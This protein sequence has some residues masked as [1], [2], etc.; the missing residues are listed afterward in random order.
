MGEFVLAQT[1]SPT[2]RF[3]SITVDLRT[4]DSGSADR[5]EHIR[6]DTFETAKYP[7]AL[8]TAE[9]VPVFSG[10]YSDGQDI[11]F[12]LPGELT[13]HGVTHAVTFAVEGKLSANTV[14]GS[15]AAIIH[16]SDFG[17]KDP[18]ITSVVPITIGKDIMLTIS[19]SAEQEAC[20]HT[21][22]PSRS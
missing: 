12:R 3:L 8:F 10:S 17:M 15:G 16:L 9:Q 1:P 7:L 14:T 19:F 18:E 4:L 11:Q 22:T 6:T 20:L 2:L 21:S 5:D 13:L